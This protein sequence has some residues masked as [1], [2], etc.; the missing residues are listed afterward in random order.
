MLIIK[1]MRVGTIEVP[2]LECMGILETPVGG[3]NS[4]PT[5]LYEQ[6]SLRP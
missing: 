5:Q 3:C 6:Y 1:L 2:S 4:P